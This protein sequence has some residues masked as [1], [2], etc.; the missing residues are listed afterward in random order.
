MNWS[1]ALFNRPYFLSK[2]I[3]HEKLNHQDNPCDPSPDYNFARCVDEYIVKKVGCQPPWRRFTFDDVP[4]CDNWTMLN[5][6][7]E[8]SSRFSERMSNDE[9]IRI[10]QCLLPCTF[11][12]YKVSFLHHIFKFSYF[13]SITDTTLH[14]ND[15]K[16]KSRIYCI[17][18]VWGT[19]GIS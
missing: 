2:P 19:W 11:M 5:R 14:V 13:D 8:V 4:S 3:R 10:T 17:V 6:Y 7:G 9:V 16:I 15:N 18:E 1:F 12:E